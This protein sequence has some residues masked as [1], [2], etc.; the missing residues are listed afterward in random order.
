MAGIFGMNETGI[1]G[2]VFDGFTQN[3]TGSILLT[4]L[5]IISILLVLALALRIPLE[6]TALLVF[7]IVLVAGAY[8]G[9]IFGAVA[10]I[11][12]YIGLILAKNFIIR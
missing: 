10:A 4:L 11:A 6:V 1:M 3:V 2:A 7:P 9:D 5:L 12:I 8:T